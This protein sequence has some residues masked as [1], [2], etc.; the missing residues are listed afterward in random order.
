MQHN[1]RQQALVEPKKLKNH[2]SEAPSKPITWCVDSPGWGGSEI[3]LL[4]VWR[5]LNRTGDTLLAR[6]N[7]A[8]PIIE[9]ASN[10][11]FT[12]LRHD[13]RNSC[14]YIF[15]ELPS[16]LRLVSK[17]PKSVFFIWSHHFDSNR[18]LQLTLANR[19]LPFVIVEQLIPTDG[20]SFKNSRLTLPIKRYVVSNARLIVLNAITQIKTYL[21]LTR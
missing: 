9:E 14:R 6:T 21:S 17:L 5:L 10:R 2:S 18:W 1:L 13:S 8:A 4:R 16:T 15:E 12:I 19:R 3:N 20:K 11:D 7:A